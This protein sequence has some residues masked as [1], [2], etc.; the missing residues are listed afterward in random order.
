MVPPVRAGGDQRCPGPRAVEIPLEHER[1]VIVGVAALVPGRVW[2]QVLSRC[3][4]PS[5]TPTERSGRCVPRAQPHRVVRAD[6]RLRAGSAPSATPP[7][8]SKRQDAGW[9]WRRTCAPMERFR[10]FHRRRWRSGIVTWPT[11][12]PSVWRATTAR[13]V[14]LG[15]ESD[16]EAWSAVGGRLAHRAGPLPVPHSAR[17][18]PATVEGL[19][20]RRGARAS[21]WVARWSSSRR[22]SSVPVE[23]CYASK[24]VISGC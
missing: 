6:G 9:A 1:D 11:R 16:T 8:A 10:T 2:P 5:R 21:F 23:G 19:P 20:R 22:R 24:A 12:W 18:G 14:A 3:S 13:T 7:P 17:L 15:S 4:R